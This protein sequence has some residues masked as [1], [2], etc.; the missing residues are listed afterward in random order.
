VPLKQLLYLPPFGPLADPHLLAD[1]AAEAEAAGFEGVF[2]WDHVLRR[3]EEVVDVLDPWV[4]LAA[5]A[6]ATRRVRVGPLVTPITRRRPIKLAREIVS[7]DLLSR[8]RLTM[9]FGL[10][11]DS[12]GELGRFGEILDP[13][14]RGDRLDEGLHIVEDLLV[15]GRSDFRGEH[16]MTEDVLF[17]PPCYQQPRPPFWFAVRGGALRPARRAAKYEGIIPIE[18]E[19]DQMQRV[20]DAV[21]E[22]R[23][24]LD[25]F[26]IVVS[27]TPGIGPHA[28]DDEMFAAGATSITRRVPVGA[29]GDDV[30]AVIRR[31]ATA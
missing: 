22:L 30:R 16:F 10:G 29:T 11:V 12:G 25:D 18:M 20:L 23:G 26:D 31:C 15:T 27:D 5:I 3:R 21:A 7:L 17:G 1:L 2:L 13:R 8:G 24:S 4:C 28:T 14:T 19:L 9:G 6:V